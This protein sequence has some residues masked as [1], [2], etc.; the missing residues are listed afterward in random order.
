MVIGPRFFAFQPVGNK[1][2]LEHDM[3][4]LME[5]YNMPYNDI[6]SMPTSRR[7]RLVKTREDIIKQRNKA[8]R[9]GK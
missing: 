1:S 3:V 8:A 4:L 5:S 7:H 6:M 2:W 9:R